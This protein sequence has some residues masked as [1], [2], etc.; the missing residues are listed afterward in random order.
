VY[1][2]KVIL[3]PTGEIE[4]IHALASKSRT[5]KQLVRDIESLLLVKFRTRIDYRCVSLVQLSTE[6]LLSYFRRPKLVSVTRNSAEEPTVEVCL[7]H[8]DGVKSVGRAQAGPRV[9]DEC[10]LAALATIQ[11]LSSL[12]PEKGEVRLKRA[13]TIPWD[14]RTVALVA[15]SLRSDRGEEQLLGATIAEQD[16]LHGVAQATLDA[17]NRRLF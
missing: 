9:Q 8:G 15:L 14:D 6:D 4:E 17:L 2:A 11:A 7:L 13:E 1:A 10:H 3:N 12:L 5:P 16:I